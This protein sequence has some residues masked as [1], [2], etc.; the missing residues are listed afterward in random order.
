MCNEDKYISDKF[1]IRVFLIIFFTSFE[2]IIL[3]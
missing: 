1:I 2:G 3:D